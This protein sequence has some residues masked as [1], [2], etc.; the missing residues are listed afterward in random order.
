MYTIL[1]IACRKIDFLYLS[2]LDFGD[3]VHNG[4]DSPEWHFTGPVR[5]AVTRECLQ[6]QVDLTKHP[7]YCH[8]IDPLRQHATDTPQALKYGGGKIAKSVVMK[9][10]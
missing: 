7:V 9:L 8:I 10:H 5:P 4:F 1:T 2:P 6:K 3:G